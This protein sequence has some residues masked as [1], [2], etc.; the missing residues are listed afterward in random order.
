MQV[1]CFKNGSKIEVKDPFDIDFIEY[2]VVNDYL[3]VIGHL[4]KNP[5]ARVEIDYSEQLIPE[6]RLVNC[7]T[8]FAE[9]FNQFIHHRQPA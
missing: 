8:I 9:K 4:E 5:S 3:K 7:S 1:T 2:D 6:Y